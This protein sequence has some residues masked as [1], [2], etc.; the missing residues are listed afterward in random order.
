[1]TV[2]FSESSSVLPMQ[3]RV[4][5]YRNM[6]KGSVTQ[7]KLMFSFT[8]GCC[9]CWWLQ[10]DKENFPSEVEI[11]RGKQFLSAWKNN[12][13]SSFLERG[14]QILIVTF[15]LVWFIDKQISLLKVYF[16]QFI[17]EVIVVS[18]FI[19]FISDTMSTYCD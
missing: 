9:W 5:V 14:Q 16:R 18:F 6:G 19:Q 4:C 3:T 11:D 13:K 2:D 10:N 8:N 7:Q 1:M 15:C 12:A 17:C